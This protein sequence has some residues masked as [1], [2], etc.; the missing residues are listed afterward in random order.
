MKKNHFKFCCVYLTEL[1]KYILNLKLQKIS[2]FK[3][4]KI[5]DEIKI[6][7][8]LELHN[9]FKFTHLNFKI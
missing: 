3:T 8:T 1:I 6:L 2:K 4:T 7:V 5:S 9:L